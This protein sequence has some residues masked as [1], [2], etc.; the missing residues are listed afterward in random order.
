MFE[1]KIKMQLGTFV[2]EPSAESLTTENVS[3]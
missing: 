1:K 2:N 3:R